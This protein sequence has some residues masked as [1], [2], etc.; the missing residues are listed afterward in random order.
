MRLLILSYL[1]ASAGAPYCRCGPSAPTTA[2]AEVERRTSCR[3]RTGC[4]RLASAY[5]SPKW[6]PNLEADPSV[7]ARLA[8]CCCSRRSAGGVSLA[9]LLW[10]QITAL[11]MLRL[12]Q[13]HSHL[14]A[15]LA[16]VWTWLAHTHKSNRRFGGSI[17]GHRAII[18]LLSW[19]RFV[20]GVLRR[21]SS[22]LVCAHPPCPRRLGLARCL[23]APLPRPKCKG[24][25]GGARRPAGPR[26]LGQSGAQP[27]QRRARAPPLGRTPAE[28]PPSAADKDVAIIIME[29]SAAIHFNVLSQANRTPLAR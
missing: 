16:I 24:A 6:T 17:L 15:G 7:P 29:K 10:S 26:R 18:E 3:L 2:R 25:K 8:L 27:G 1:V 14:S 12:F 23:S 22:A 11:C 4:G 19:A 13:L 9:G 20:R 5:F 21:P 28:R